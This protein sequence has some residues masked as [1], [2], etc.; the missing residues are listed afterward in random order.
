M[1][2]LTVCDKEKERRG[3]ERGREG[4]CVTTGALAVVKRRLTPVLHGVC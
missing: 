2:K 1:K 3:E 4:C